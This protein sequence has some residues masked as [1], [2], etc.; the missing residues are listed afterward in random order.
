MTASKTAM[1]HVAALDNSETRWALTHAKPRGFKSFL[2]IEEY[3]WSAHIKVDFDHDKN[4]P[5]HRSFKIFRDYVLASGVDNLPWVNKPSEFKI[6]QLFAYTTRKGSHLRLWF[7]FRPSDNAIL[8]MQSMLGDD[9]KRQEFN[10][11]RVARGAVGW[12]VLWT[13]KAINGRITSE[14]VYSEELTL[15]FKRWLKVNI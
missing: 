2:A 12:D 1:L 14:E 13:K 10:A 3:G 7:N 11:A 15:K 6:A 4:P 8:T 9:A 5:R